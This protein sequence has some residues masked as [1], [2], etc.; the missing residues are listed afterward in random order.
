MTVLRTPDDRFENLS[1]FSFPP[2]Y[3]EVA[4]EGL[5]KLRIHYLDEGPAD[6]PVV[7]CLHGEPTWSYLYRKMIP[8]FAAA[9]CRVLAPDLI[10][11]GRSD[12]PSERTDSPMTNTC[13]G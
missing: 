1:G 6:G 5:G 8:V 3:V 9:G 11:F 12:K 2:N 10:G 7:L 13:N 4:D